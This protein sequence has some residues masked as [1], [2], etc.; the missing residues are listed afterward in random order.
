M[1]LTFP[2][3]AKRS[4]VLERIAGR[5]VDLARADWFVEWI[6]EESPTSQ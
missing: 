6:R 3:D 4:V 2:V 5:P 1:G